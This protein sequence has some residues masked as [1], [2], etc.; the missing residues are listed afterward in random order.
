V[1]KFFL[2]RGPASKSEHATENTPQKPF[3]D[4]SQH[5]KTKYNK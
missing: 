1:G 4:T 2:Y 5:F 3:E